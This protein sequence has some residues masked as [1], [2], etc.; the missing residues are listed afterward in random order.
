MSRATGPLTMTVGKVLADVVCHLSWCI[1][2]SRMA[3]IAAIST[4]RYSGRPPAMARATARVSTVAIPPLGMTLPT[5]ASGAMSVPLD[6][7][8]TRAS[9]GGAS[10]NP[11]PHR[12]LRNNWLNRAVASSWLPASTRSRGGTDNPF[13]L[14]AGTQE[15]RPA[16]NSPSA[17]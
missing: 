5:S 3:A 4:A 6:I 8:A 15:V 13:C 9:V 1:A 10:G 12:L 7:H 17:R 14:A 16:M 2:A 11:S